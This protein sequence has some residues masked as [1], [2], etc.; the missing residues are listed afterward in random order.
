MLAQ[1]AQR[2]LD[3][4]SRGQT[5]GISSRSIGR[6][7]GAGGP[8]AY[9]KLPP[10]CWV[11]AAR[12]HRGPTSRA[13]LRRRVRC[14]AR[15][16][17]RHRPCTARRRCSALAAAARSGATGAPNRLRAA[18]RGAERRR[19][20]PAR[21]QSMERRRAKRRRGAT[22]R[23]R[24]N[25]WGRRHVAQALQLLP[26]ATALGGV[27]VAVDRGR[28]EHCH[29]PDAIAISTPRENGK[30]LYTESSAVAA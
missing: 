5:A 17:T 22:N 19:E 30:C 8:R 3:R 25:A 9:P 15:S 26:G 24:R 14:T 18:K 10:A 16:G 6:R 7:L 1:I 23:R 27:V 29:Q 2:A 11:A 28:R 20:A 4:S 12:A 21:C 13:A